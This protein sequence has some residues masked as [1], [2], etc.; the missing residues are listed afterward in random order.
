MGRMAQRTY[1]L[2]EV[3]EIIAPGAGA[4]T[5]DKIARRIRHWTATDLLVPVEGKSTGTGISRR[6]DA[7]EVRKTAILVELANY[8]VPAT[9]LDPAFANFSDTWAES[10]HWATAISGKRSIYFQ[11]ACYEDNMSFQIAPRDAPATIL[12]PMPGLDTS[13]ERSPVSAIVVNLTRLF[14][15]LKL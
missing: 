15:G 11:F 13:R 10:P 9:V 2:K 4:D 5:R 7:D 12:D 8:R 14:A 1:T 3:V 6:Y